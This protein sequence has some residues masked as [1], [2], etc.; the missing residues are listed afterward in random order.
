MNRIG[1][2]SGLAPLAH[3]QPQ[4]AAAR[5]PCAPSSARS[6]VRRLCDRC[7]R[8]LLAFVGSTGSSPSR[9]RSASGGEPYLWPRLRIFGRAVLTAPLRSRHRS[10]DTGRHGGSRE[11]GVRRPRTRARRAR[12]RARRGAGGERRDGP[13]RRRSGHRQDPARLRARRTRPRRR[14]RGPP[15]AL[16]RSR[17]H[18]AAVPAVRRGAASARR[19]RGRSTGRRRARSC[20]CSRTTLALLAERAATAPVLLVLEDLHW[21]DAS[22]LDLVVFLAHNLD[23]RPVLLL[24]TYRADEPASAARMR[25]LADGVRRS[26]SA[27]VLELGP[28]EREELPELLAARADNAAAGGPDGRDRR[29]LRRAIPSSPRSSSPRRRARRGAPAG[30]ARRAAAARRPARPADAGRAAPG[31]GRRARRRVPAA[32]RSGGAPGARPARVAASGRR[33]RRPGRRRRRGASASATRCW[34]RPSTRP[35]CQGSARSCTRGSPRSSRAADGAAPAELAPHWAAAGRSAEALAASVEAARRAEAVFGLAEA[36]AHLD[37]ALALWDAVPGAAERAGLDL[38]QLCEWA[39]EL[40]SQVS[41]AARAVELTRRAVELVGTDDPYRAAQLH[42]RLGEYLTRR[43]ATMPAWPRSSALSSSHPPI[44][45]RRSGRT[46]SG[47]S[48]AG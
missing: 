5:A 45:P 26:G 18:G 46:R 38:A 32:P 19:R 29:P 14:V 43:A 2:P 36:L 31:R 35:S 33:A 4:A 48:R 42:V 10:R 6:R 24:A 15:R 17:R 7:H 12:A 30:A 37:R 22:T 34:R 25:R 8:C 16:D 13:R 47:R 23:A 39:G 44:R 20:G 41:P 40:A 9:S 21:A 1:G 11:R 3:V 27:L 28:L